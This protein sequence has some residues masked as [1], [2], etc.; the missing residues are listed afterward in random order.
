[1][2]K[3]IAML[4]MERY[5]NRPK[6]SV[7]S[8]RIR[9][10]WLM[11]YWDEIEEYRIG[12]EYKAIIFQKAYFPRYMKIFN[13]IKILDM[14]DPDWLEQKP[15]RETIDLCDA[16]VVATEPLREFIAQMTDKPVI[17]IPD[18]VD[19]DELRD[20]KQHEG[21]AR[22]AV[23]FGYSSN[24]KV[25]DSC[26]MTLKRLNMQLTVVS[27]LPYYP[28]ASVADISQEWIRA[29]IT[30][31]KYDQRMINQDILSGDIVLNPKID[32]GRF[33]FKSENKTLIAWAL[34][35]PVAKDSEDLE[36]FVSEEERTKEAKI[37]LDEIQ[38]NH[39]VQKSVQQYKE[40]INDL[41]AKKAQ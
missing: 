33:R 38:S 23:W 5:E 4:T 3:Q 15:V 24:H 22:T 26:L 19:M 27:E 25:I 6:D 1:M 11:K 20:K 35:M 34:G 10:R 21:T 9:G 12:R 7:G 37:R 40:L 18:R 17:V 29:N 39:L 32:S 14:C 28:T 13:G 16:V 36:R 31:V 8:S 2:N 41:F 30:N